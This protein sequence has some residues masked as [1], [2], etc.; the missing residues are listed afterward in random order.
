MGRH[1]GADPRCF[2]SGFSTARS[3]PDVPATA[4]CDT[5]FMLVLVSDG[6]G[7]VDTFATTGI[8]CHQVSPVFAT[9]DLGFAVGAQ[10]IVLE[11]APG[12]QPLLEAQSFHIAP[13]LYVWSDVSSGTVGPLLIRGR[14]ACPS[15]LEP[16]A[17]REEPGNQ[18]L[19]AWAYASA[20]VEVEAVVTAS[21]STLV[22]KALRWNQA[23]GRIGMRAVAR[24][25]GCKTPGCSDSPAV[26][27]S[28]FSS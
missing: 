27:G 18:A 21:V 12:S 16:P 6:D 14:T 7:A 24:R 3:V 17:R 20:L 8:R 13:T 26:G 1:F 28:L 5:A 25:R 2:S 9:N 23:R 22:G 4:A 11:F 10:M 15:C 19:L